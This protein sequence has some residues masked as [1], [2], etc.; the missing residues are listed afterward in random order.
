MFVLSPATTDRLPIQRLRSLAAL[1]ISSWRKALNRKLCE[2]REASML[3]RLDRRLLEDFGA[4]HFAVDE[5]LRDTSHP[6]ELTAG[7]L[8][9]I[10]VAAYWRLPRKHS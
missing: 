9:A 7:P 10:Y 4:Q 8:M 1:I 6:G 5:Q 2:R 3:R